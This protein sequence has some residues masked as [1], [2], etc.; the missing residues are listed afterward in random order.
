VKRDTVWSYNNLMP[1]GDTDDDD[2]RFGW[3]HELQRWLFGFANYH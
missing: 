1:G 3:L 2:S